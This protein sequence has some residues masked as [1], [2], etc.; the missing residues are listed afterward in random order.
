MLIRNVLVHVDTSPRSAAAVEAASSLARRFDARLKGFF[1]VPDVAV[2]AAVPGGAAMS[3]QIIDEMQKDAEDQASEAEKLFREK[4][5]DLAAPDH[6][7]RAEAMGIGSRAA[8]AKVAHFAD[9]LVAGHRGD[10]D[11]EGNGSAAALL[12]DLVL[13]AGRPVL[14]I[15]ATGSGGP[16]GKNVLIAW[17]ESREAT[18]AVYDAMPFLEAADTITVA[19][20]VK[21]VEG[22]PA[23]G[24]A[25]A[26]ILRDHGLTVSAVAIERNDGST[27]EALFNH[28]KKIG[29]DLL[30]AGAY[31]HSRLREGLFGGVTK[32]ILDAA[33][34][35][36][37]LSH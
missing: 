30:V 29:A 14:L 2:A 27:S 22:G 25:I 23:P 37:L 32:S 6:W 28:A 10:E 15:P 4:A 31:S 7:I 24:E 17:T 36:A 33:P 11:G 8:A 1:V 5:G 18:R 34:L 16:V 12:Q 19:T 20:V 21:K 35:P 13:D 9:L 3:S 26:G